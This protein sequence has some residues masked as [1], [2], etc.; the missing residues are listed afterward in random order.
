MKMILFKLFL[1]YILYIKKNYKKICYSKKGK[2]F[3]K[4]KKFKTFLFVVYFRGGY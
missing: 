3:F 1:I 2:K 4:I